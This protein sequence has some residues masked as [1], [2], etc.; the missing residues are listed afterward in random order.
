MRLA[1][2][3]LAVVGVLL[4]LAVVG[5]LVGAFAVP[6][7]GVAD[8]GD[9]GEVSENRTEVVTTVWVNNP[10]P[11]VSVLGSDL[12]LEYDLALNGVD[13]AAGEREGLSVERGNQ[14]RE[15]TT[16][17]RN[18]RIRAW[19]VE[20]VR[21]NETVD[22]DVRATIGTR[23]A[24]RRASYTVERNATFLENESPMIDAMTEAVNGTEGSYPSAAPVYEVRD[25][26]AEWGAV[27]RTRTLVHVR[28][29]VYNPSS[30]PVPAAPEGI[31]ATVR[32]NDV[33][34]LRTE[35]QAYELSGVGRDE[36]I[37]P[38]ESREYT[39]TLRIDNE[40]IDDWFRS[41][42]RQDERTDLE[43]DFQATVR[44]P[45]TGD[46]VGLPPGGVTYTCEMQT[47]IFVDDAESGTTCGSGGGVG[48]GVDVGTP[49][50]DLGAALASAMTAGVTPASAVTVGPTPAPAATVGTAP[51]VGDGDASAGRPSAGESRPW[52]AVGLRNG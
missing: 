18:D 29:T 41:H 16:E 3:G 10:N 9:W 25:A 50:A 37:P 46:A 2:V 4:V 38:G 11:L 30:V 7:A 36:V 22:A 20:Y 44:N 6:S 42:V 23:A 51:R 33:E 5:L 12:D 15:F 28:F 43:V 49:D 35:G 19:W 8:Q 14:T 1:R 45:L 24:F 47:G 48:V 27:N 31:S 40:R 21:T 17:L 52:P 32:A 34:L 26:R 39:V 13:L